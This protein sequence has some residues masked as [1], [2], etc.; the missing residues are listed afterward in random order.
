MGIIIINENGDI[1]DAN[2]SVCEHLDLPILRIKGYKIHELFKESIFTENFPFFIAENSGE[3]L[4]WNSNNSNVKKSFNVRAEILNSKEGNKLIVLTLMDVTNELLTKQRLKNITDN[5]PG[6]VFRYL[7]KDSGEDQLIYVSERSQDLW[8]Y[9]QKELLKDNNLV[10]GNYHPE[11]IKNHKISILESKKDLNDWSHEWRYYHPS[12]GLRWHR[13]IGKPAKLNNGDVAWDS[14]VFDITDEK[15]IE[16]ESQVLKDEIENILVQSPDMI[17]TISKEGKFVKVS[18]ASFNIQGYFPDELIGEYFIDFVAEEWS[19]ETINMFQDLLNGNSTRN[20]ENNYYHKNGSIVPLVWSAR[21]DDSNKLLYCIARDGREKRKQEQALQTM[22]ER[23][24]LATQATNEIIWESDVLNNTLFF[25]E[26]FKK[27][28]DFELPGEFK[29]AKYYNGLI[30]EN[31]RE[32]IARSLKNALLNKNKSKWEEKYKIKNTIN[33]FITVIDSAIIIRDESGKALKMVGAIKD[34][35]QLEKANQ[36]ENFEKVILS[37]SLKPETTLV[38]LSKSFAEGIEQIIPQSKCSILSVIDEK[39]YNLSSPSLPN[40]LIDIIEGENI[41]PM[42]AS[43]GAS[44]YTNKIVIVDDIL[45]DKK[46]K[47]FQ[48]VARDFSLKSCWS[49]PVQNSY[50][51]V[52]ATIGVYKDHI[53]TPK[54][55][56][57]KLLKRFASLLGILIEKYQNEEKIRKSNEVYELV[58]KASRDA[59]YELDLIEDHIK[60]GESYTNIFGYSIDPKAKFPLEEW[61]KNVHPDDQQKTNDSWNDF[62]NS[63]K[64]KWSFSYRYL[65]RNNTYADVLE[66][67]YLIRDK[68]NKPLRMI[69][70]LRDISEQKKLESLYTRSSKIAKIGSWEVDLRNKNVYW[71]Q[72]TKEI[73]E[74]D[75]SFIPSYDNA[76]TNFFH[77]L[78]QVKITNAF[79]DAIEFNKT[80]DIEAQLITAKNRTK[81]IRL[82]G[83][84]ELLQNKVVKLFGSMQDIDFR[85]RVELE[86]IEKTKFL[87]LLS[88][89]NKELLDYEKWDKSII[90]IFK[91]VGESVDIDRVYFFKIFHEDGVEKLKQIYEWCSE[92]TFP[93]IDDP[94]LKAIPTS[95]IPSIR[96]S[97]HKNE[98]FQVI[99]SSMENGSEKKLFEESDIKSIYNTP[100][101]IKQR[102]FGLF[103]F[104]DCTK[105]KVWTEQEIFFL[106]Y[107][108]TKYFHSL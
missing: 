63:T 87:T 35:S 52:V 43:C 90:K 41:G 66:N 28:F 14:I 51:Q 95:E 36:I 101:H 99:T 42:R 92:N 103:G 4:Q 1:I 57:I 18:S 38:S 29:N 74:T 69:G 47:D 33:S 93:Q 60:W 49:V 48:F 86:L 96:S 32:E 108:Y 82:T 31:M 44:A 56:E 106:F 3:I 91:I 61:Y 12:K 54:N 46:W 40:E 21:W 64:H 7:L 13:G 55:W 8:G 107:S 22:N 20:F 79:S 104:D 5:I 37:K 88:E 27:I 65:K 70:V 68:N 105:E 102:L 45:N 25:S 98:P 100:V 72:I 75:D 73:H 77:E 67:G 85:K 15:T 81:W 76:L 59:I 80:I 16:K 50:E 89:I 62:L 11:D 30:H 24:K 97:I 17:C 58:N 84:T 6:T 10:W 94:R 78:Y 83:E 9:N 2:S 26:N 39:L 34:I 71:S 53:Y 23:Y 19:K